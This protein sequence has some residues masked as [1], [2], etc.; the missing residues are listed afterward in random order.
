MPRTSRPNRPH[1]STH[2]YASSCSI[3]IESL[4]FEKRLAVH[5]AYW[6]GSVAHALTLGGDVAGLE[7]DNP[8]P[9]SDTLAHL[10]LKLAGRWV[11]TTPSSRPWYRRG[12]MCV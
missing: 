8:R 9:A 1:T 11:R 5:E 4:S 10:L 3:Y 12:Y 2:R 7:A 6:L